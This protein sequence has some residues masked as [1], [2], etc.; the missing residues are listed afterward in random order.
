MNKKIA[1]V[2]V[3]LLLIG[4]VSAGLVN[5]LS[6]TV[7]GTVSVECPTF[8]LTKDKADLKDISGDLIEVYLLGINSYTGSEKI[9]NKEINCLNPPGGCE[10]EFLNFFTTEELNIDSFYK[11]KWKFFSSL[12]IINQTE[13]SGECK[14]YTQL[15][16]VNDASGKGEYNLLNES[17][18]SIPIPVKGPT[19]HYEKI[20]TIINID[21]IEMDKEDRFYTRYWI[22]C[23]DG[24]YNLRFRINDGNSKIKISAT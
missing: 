23:D 11:S 17:K 12:K 13:E 16:L 18:E 19:G 1:S 14:L 24:K 2:L 5:Y 15:Y 10:A 4:I 22:T 21:P 7:T 20:E 3:G 9:F 6:N 8:Y